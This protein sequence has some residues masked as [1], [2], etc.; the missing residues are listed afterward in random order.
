MWHPLQ[1][2]FRRLLTRALAIEPGLTAPRLE[3]IELDGKLVV[4]YGKYDLGCGWERIPH[5][6]TL[7]VE[8]DDSFKLGIDS[9]IYAMT[10]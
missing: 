7:A 5:P 8:M 6:S 9:I 10:H 2:Q 3:G 1:A 4:V